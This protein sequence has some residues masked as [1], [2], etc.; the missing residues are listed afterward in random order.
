[1]F[2]EESINGFKNEPKD[3]II[4]KIFLQCMNSFSVKVLKHSYLFKIAQNSASC[5]GFKNLKY[6]S[7]LLILNYNHS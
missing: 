4:I 7:S 2:N 5:N 6:K 3:M 1:M